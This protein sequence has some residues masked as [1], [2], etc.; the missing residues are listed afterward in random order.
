[1]MNL[2]SGSLNAIRNTLIGKPAPEA[3][4]E[5]TRA[6]DPVRPAKGKDPQFPS[7]VFVPKRHD[8]VSAHDSKAGKDPK[9]AKKKFDLPESPMDS[10]SADPLAST[11]MMDLPER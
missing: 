9:P 10:V 1:M 2:V 8:S 6:T 11:W 5:A 7:T 3:D 4:F